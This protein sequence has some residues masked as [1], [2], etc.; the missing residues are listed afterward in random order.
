[1]VSFNAF[2][3]ICVVNLECFFDS[4]VF[5]EYGLMWEFVWGKVSELGFGKKFSKLCLWWGISTYVLYIFGLVKNFVCAMVGFA[6][7]EE[8]SQDFYIFVSLLQCGILWK[9]N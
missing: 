6:C 4:L 2:G 5:C 9:C 3:Y 1:M 7:I 8:G